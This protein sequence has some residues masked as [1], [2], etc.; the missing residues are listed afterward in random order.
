MSELPSHSGLFKRFYGLHYFASVS[1]VCVS[2]SMQL[3]ISTPVSMSKVTI[4]CFEVLL[5]ICL[6]TYV[7]MYVC[8]YVCCMYVCMYVR[9][10]I[11]MYVCVCDIA[12][13]VTI[14]SRDASTP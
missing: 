7:C 13:C 10:Y 1:T 6:C 14:V 9:M 5:M 12:N 4:L 2:W 3:F 8:V 11:C